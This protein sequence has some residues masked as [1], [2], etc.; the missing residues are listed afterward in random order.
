MILTDRFLGFAEHPHTSQG[1]NK[2]AWLQRE[3]IFEA[4]IEYRTSERR[5]TENSK[6]QHIEESVKQTLI[7]DLPKDLDLLFGVKAKI[8]IRGTRYGSLSVFFGA[9]LAA[10]GI[11]SAYK[12]FWDSVELIRQQ[13]EDLLNNTLNRG[14][15]RE[16]N[17]RVSTRY[18]MG[19]R[20]SL[21]QRDVA[22]LLHDIR[23]ELVF[24]ARDRDQVRP[25]EMYR[26]RRDGLFYFL[27]ILCIIESAV[28][29]LLVYGAVM[30]VYF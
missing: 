24:R 12:D 30:Q 10:Y 17:I 9:I 4:R 26:P 2:M 11:L 19:Y 5:I 20:R 22:I 16:F 28:I 15:R 27:L 13:A 7:V 8:H 6:I 1:E 14:G 25:Y 18:P 3:V 29:G 21:L 23:H